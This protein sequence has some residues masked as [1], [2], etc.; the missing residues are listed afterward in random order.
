MKYAIF[1]FVATLLMVAERAG[2]FE[3]ATPNAEQTAR[4]AEFSEPG[5]QNFCPAAYKV[6][7]LRLPTEA[8]TFGALSGTG[9]MAI[10]KPE[11]NGLFPAIVLLHTCGPVGSDQTR[12]WTKAAIENGYAVFILDSWSQRNLPNG[13]CDTNPGFNVTAVRLRDA[14][15]ALS[16]L[17]E[18]PM[19]DVNRVAAIGFSY[20]ARLAYMLSNTNEAKMF[21]SQ[22]RHFAATVSLYGEC[23]NRLSKFTWL[24]APVQVPVLALLGDSDNDGDIRECEPRLKELKEAG[25]PVEWH[26]YPGVGHVFDDPRWSPSKMRPYPGSVTGNVLY[27]YDGKA[28]QDARDR[29]FAFLNPI[30]KK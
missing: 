7:G 1:L 29:V 11:G 17:A 27:K 14:Y 25:A 23:Y 15:D 26:I 2:A 13:S 21:A 18:I 20:G 10:Y 9:S 19:M 5:Q 12:F 8:S 22:D 6:A 4:C 24:K 16:H 3:A 30:L 28:A